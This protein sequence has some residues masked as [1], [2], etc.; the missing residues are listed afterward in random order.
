MILS[1]LAAAAVATAPATAATQPRPPVA[2]AKP[3]A[4]S[5]SLGDDQKIVCV[6]EPMPGSRLSAR[7]CATVADLR[8]RGLLDRQE[9]EHMQ[10][11]RSPGY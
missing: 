8:A 9:L 6:T 10:Q 4:T 2:T 11:D 1:L 3:A 7:R 5:R